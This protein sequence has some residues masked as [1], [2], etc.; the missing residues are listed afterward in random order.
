MSPFPTRAIF[1][2]SPGAEPKLI[3]VGF[4]RDTLQPTEV[5]IENSASGLCH[6]DL[7][8]MDG[9]LPQFTFPVIPGHEGAGVVMEIGKEVVGLA[10]GDQVLTSWSYCGKCRMCERGRPS[11]CEEWQSRNLS[12]SRADGSAAFETLNDP[13]PDEK[14][15]SQLIGQAALAKHMIVEQ[16]SCVKLPAPVSKSD[17][18]WLAPLGCG[19]ITGAGTIFNCIPKP[20]KSGSTIAVFG[21][22]A[23]GCAALMAAKSVDIFEEIVA[24]DIHPRRLELAKSL[25]ATSVVLSDGTNDVSPQV[26]AKTEKLVGVDYAIEC[27]G[28]SSCMKEAYGSLANGGMLCLVGIARPGTKMDFD[29]LAHVNDMKTVQGCLEGDCVPSD[30]IPRL[31]Q[32]NKEG[33]FPFYQL[34]KKYPIDKFGEAM[35]DMKTGKV[36]KPILVWD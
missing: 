25:G 1:V 32:L 7:I 15:G 19:F 4:K 23:V 31:I 21:V 30:L 33:Q 29:P 17:L 12:G 26:K 9:H 2:Q 13:P 22:G 20:I 10:V 14:I 35:N 6:S 3:D 36:I 16:S 28:L 27:T 8:L 18:D 34:C 11:V 5:I 24:I